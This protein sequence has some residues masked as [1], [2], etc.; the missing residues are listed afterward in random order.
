MS[1]VSVQ[2]HK[3]CSIS[4][5]RQFLL[6]NSINILFSNMWT[7]NFWIE[8]ETR[9]YTKGV[10]VPVSMSR[11]C[12]HVLRLTNSFPLLNYLRKTK[13]VEYEKKPLRIHI[14]IILTWE[15][16]GKVWTSLNL[17]TLLNLK[18]VLKLRSLTLSDKGFR[19]NNSPHILNRLEIHSFRLYEEIWP[20]QDR[21]IIDIS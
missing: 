1:D 6:W 10:R 16:L 8:N 20:S 13:E 3:N 4:I 17:L 2:R 7:H 19:L 18:F 14:E 11:K 15:R 9:T 5:W 21:C 12:L